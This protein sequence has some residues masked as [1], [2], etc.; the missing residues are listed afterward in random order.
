MKEEKREEKDAQL[1]QQAKAVLILNHTLPVI[2][3]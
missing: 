2:L 1:W 3:L